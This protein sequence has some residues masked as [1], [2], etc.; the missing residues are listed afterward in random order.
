M[1]PTWP[2]L[3]FRVF[4]LGKGFWFVRLMKGVCRIQKVRIQ[5]LIRVISSLGMVCF[6]RVQ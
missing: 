3:G 2:Y 5:G 1:T 4:G 6:A